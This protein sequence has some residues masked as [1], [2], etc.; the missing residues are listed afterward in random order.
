M[1]RKI[2]VLSILRKR[3]KEFPFIKEQ[4]PN[5]DKISYIDYQ[6]GKI[7]KFESCYSRYRKNK[8]QFL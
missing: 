1:E 7:M 8:D 2:F 6:T 3:I 5:V 4:N